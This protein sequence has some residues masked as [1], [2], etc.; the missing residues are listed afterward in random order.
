MGYFMNR[1]SEVILRRVHTHNP[2]DVSKA[3]NLARNVEEETYDDTARIRH[4]SSGI[5]IVG[6]L[7]G[8]GRWTLVE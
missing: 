5:I 4:R 6:L 2:Q 3:I 7:H 8:L 1:L